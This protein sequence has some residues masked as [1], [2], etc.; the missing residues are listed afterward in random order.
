METISHI[1][2]IVFYILLLAPSQISAQVAN[3][4]SG[5]RSQ[6]LGNASV[7]YS[8]I[9]SVFNN[10][11]ALAHL[12]EP[13]IGTEYKNMYQLDGFKT[14]SLCANLP[15]KNFN[16]GLGIYYFGDE[17]YNEGKLSIGASHKI[18]FVSLGINVNYLQYNVIE[19]RS[20]YA[21]AIELGGLVQIHPNW[22]FGAHLFNANQASLSGSGSFKVPTIMRAGISYLPKESTMLTAEIEKD[23]EKKT[24]LKVG[25][26]YAIVKQL[27]L[28]SGVSTYPSNANFGIGFLSKQINLDYAAS[29]HLQLGL[30]H[31]LSANIILK[32]KHEAL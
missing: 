21:F 10:I 5:A 9:W 31:Q 13:V 8:D 16:T 29:H 20:S 15:H 24:C 7:A 27:I 30:S 19:F 6:G 26:E 28:R 2:F 4:Q 25:A 3:Y 23:P 14:A 11:G 12:K 18:N 1:R 32:R 22:N 17:I